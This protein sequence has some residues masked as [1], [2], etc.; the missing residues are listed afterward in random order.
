[1]AQQ[2]KKKKK[3]VLEEFQYILLLNFILTLLWHIFSI[4]IFYIVCVIDELSSF[5]KSIMN[6]LFS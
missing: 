6:P 1:M 4:N 2:K 5:Q 3:I